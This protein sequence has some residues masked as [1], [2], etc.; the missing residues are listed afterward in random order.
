M[1][2]HQTGS[3]LDLYIQ[4]PATGKL[5]APNADQVRV[6]NENGWYQTAGPNDM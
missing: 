2:K 4:D 6:L 1:S 3:A 5:L